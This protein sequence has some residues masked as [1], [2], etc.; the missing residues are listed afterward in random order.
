MKGGARARSGPSP[1]PEALRRDRPDDGEWTV[2]PASGREG[3]AP[4]WPLTKA[5][6]LETTMWRQHWKLPQAIMWERL[7]QHRLVA[8]YVRRAIEA[9]AR[10]S[11][12][13]LSTFV[14]QMADSLGLTTPGIRANRWRIGSA[15]PAAPRTSG[16]PGRPN[17]RR[18]L[19]VVA[20]DVEGT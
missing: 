18:R 16:A 8:L 5:T 2:L 20:T 4:K 6:A 17:A 14:R 3:A 7:H 1:D 10:N 19:Q 13:N 11:P 15:E 9:E 12:V